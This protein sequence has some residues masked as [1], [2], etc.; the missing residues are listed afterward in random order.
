VHGARN[1]E[2]DGSTKPWHMLRHWVRPFLSSKIPPDHTTCFAQICR[3]QFGHRHAVFW[4]Q[5]S[6]GTDDK[7]ANNRVA[8]PATFGTSTRKS[9][10]G[11]VDHLLWRES[12]EHVENWAEAD[13][14]H[15]RVVVAKLSAD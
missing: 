6:Q 4:R 5:V 8:N 11:S 1:A 14:D 13:L 2:F 10:T 7:A 12:F 3:S 15:P 9:A